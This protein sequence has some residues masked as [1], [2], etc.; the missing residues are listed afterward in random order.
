[1]ITNLSFTISTVVSSVFRLICQLQMSTA[2]FKVMV[3]AIFILIRE[4]KMILRIVPI[5]FSGNTIAPGQTKNNNCSTALLWYLNQ[6]PVNSIVY[7]NGAAVES[8]FLYNVQSK[9]GGTREYQ[10]KHWRMIVY[11][12]F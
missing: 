2:L 9:R 4:L 5:H 3:L 6:L 7:D 10:V 12:E 1:M 8:R 11:W